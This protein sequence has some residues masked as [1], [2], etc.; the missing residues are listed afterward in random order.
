MYQSIIDMY[1]TKEIVRILVLD[2][3]SYTRVYFSDG[4]SKVIGTPREVL[5]D[6]N[7]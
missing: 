1:P 7:S 5:F 2:N 6:Y 3:E 4:T